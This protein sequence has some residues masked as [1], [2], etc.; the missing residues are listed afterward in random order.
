MAW[1]EQRGTRW[2]VRFRMPDGTVGTD[3]SHPTRAAAQLRR[4]QVDIDQATDTYLD[5]AAGRISLADWVELWA[6]THV[7]G[8]AK[9][10]AYRSHLRNHIL[11]RFGS[12][13]LVQIN[14]HAVKV[15]VKQLMWNGVVKY[16][17]W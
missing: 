12:V 10:A 17:L 9:M 2:R 4:K 13:P 5:P 14:R 1:V 15:F 11:P 3:S 16:H 6:D 7:A 8:P